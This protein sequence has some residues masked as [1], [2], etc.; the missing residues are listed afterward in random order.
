VFLRRL[1]GALARRGH[2]VDIIHDVDAYDMLR[3]G[4]EPDPLPEPEGVTL[5]P[6]RSRMGNLS[7]LATQQTGRPIVHGARIREILEQG[8]FDVIHFHNISLV[9]GPGVL[10]YGDA[11]KLYMAHEHWLVCASHVLW[12]H[13]RELCTGRECLRCV[14]RHGRPPQL[15]R[16]TGLLERMCEHVDAFISPSAFSVGKHHQFGFEPEMQ[17]IPYFLPDLDSGAE[18]EAPRSGDEQ[19]EPYFLFVGRLEKIKGL[20]DVFE[21]FGENAVANLCVVGTG[22]YEQELHALADGTPRVRFLGLRSPEELRQLYRNALAV[23]VPSIC[24]ETFGIILLEAFRDSTPVIARK[25]GPF[26]EIVESS[27]GGLLFETGAELGAAIQQLAGDPE[28][29]SRLGQQGHH[30][31][32]TRWT[33]SA[34]LPQYFQLI[35][36]VAEQ[37]GD[38]RVIEML[39]EAAGPAREA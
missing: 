36:Q 30:A 15:W 5:H 7:C 33:E 26:P 11:I 35:A 28:L 19:T 14:L 17:V 39:P 37:R 9:G 31:L 27:G 20:Q 12:R 13:G 23:I 21:H 2:T 24:Y 34:V 6:L 22:D 18:G 16:S 38:H 1:V 3:P 10:A 29:R 4:G 8:D 32:L 25:L